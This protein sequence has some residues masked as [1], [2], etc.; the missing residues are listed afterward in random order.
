MRLEYDTPPGPPVRRGHS[1]YGI[2]ALVAA[3]LAMADV[4]AVNHDWIPLPLLPLAFGAG[5]FACSASLVACCAAALD[6]NV[7]HLFTWIGAGAT[8]AV[9][10]V[11]YVTTL[12]FEQFV[13]NLIRQ[14]Q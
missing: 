1:L 12:P 14:L 10:V 2:A 4:T 11:G 7:N 13:L 9:P 3:L 8:A 5:A 6:G